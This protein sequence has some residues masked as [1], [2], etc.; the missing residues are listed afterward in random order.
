MFSAGPQQ[1]LHFGSTNANCNP[2]NKTNLQMPWC[3]QKYKFPQDIP[4]C[5]CEIINDCFF[6]SQKILANLSFPMEKY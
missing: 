3:I 2:A 4:G 1:H 6:E 5:N